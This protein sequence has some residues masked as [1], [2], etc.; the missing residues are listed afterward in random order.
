M[1]QRALSTAALALDRNELTAADGQIDP[2]EQLEL[3]QPWFTGR[4]ALG[5]AAQ[6]DRAHWCTLLA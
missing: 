3:G 2:P 1:K 5:D 6:L 4:I